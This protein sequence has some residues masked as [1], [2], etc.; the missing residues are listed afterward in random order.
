MHVLF[1]EVKRKKWIHTLRIKQPEHKKKNY[2]INY[3]Y[4]KI[5]NYKLFGL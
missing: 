3:K 4:Y 1:A 2:T 5:I